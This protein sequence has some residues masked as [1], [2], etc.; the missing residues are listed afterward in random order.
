MRLGDVLEYREPGNRSTGP[1]K[2]QIILAIDHPHLTTRANDPV[3]KRRRGCALLRSFYLCS[4]LGSIVGMDEAIEEFPCVLVVVLVEAEYSTSLGRPFQVTSPE[5]PR[6]TADTRNSQHSRQFLLT[7]AELC[8]LMLGVP[9]QLLFHDR[10]RHAEHHDADRR[11]GHQYGQQLR[12]NDVVRNSDERVRGELDGRHCDEMQSAYRGYEQ[13]CRKKP[14]SPRGPAPCNP[15]CRRGKR[16]PNTLG[17][18]YVGNVPVGMG[19]HTH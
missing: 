8:C 2:N 15:C 3:F 5:I 11:S 14:V 12:G 4:D 1:V 18:Y 9:T 17:H 13:R 10:C 6:Y 16:N 7:A 19:R